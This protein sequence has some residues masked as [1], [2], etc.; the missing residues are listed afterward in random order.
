MGMTRIS[1]DNGDN[2]EKIHVQI[3]AV[4]CGLATVEL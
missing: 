3:E 4:A 2:E 1:A